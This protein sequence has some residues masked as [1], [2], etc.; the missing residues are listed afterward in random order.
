MLL[1]KTNFLRPLRFIRSKAQNIASCTLRGAQL[2]AARE[3]SAPASRL[4]ATNI[5]N[6]STSAGCKDDKQ[7]EL[8]TDHRQKDYHM[9]RAFSQFDQKHSGKIS[10]ADMKRALGPGHLG[11]GV[12][13]R[14]VD[15]VVNSMPSSR[16]SRRHTN[17]MRSDRSNMVT[18]RRFCRRLD[19]N[20][21]S[22]P[23]PEYNSFV[24]ETAGL[25]M[26][27]RPSLGAER[28]IFHPPA[29]T[30]SADAASSPALVE[31]AHGPPIGHSGRL[32]G[33][34][35]SWSRAL[36]PAHMCAWREACVWREES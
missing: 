15:H 9:M 30:A 20:N 14:D 28:G 19:L 24:D 34:E 17:R 13:E 8:K 7:A 25:A 21:S 11:L 18:Y 3:G 22:D 5:V 1:L 6:H 35:C 23:S 32:T 12:R 10:V 4:A 27:R 36:S 2:T 29:C 31:W 16:S 26:Q 33:R